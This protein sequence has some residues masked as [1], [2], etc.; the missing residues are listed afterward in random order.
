MRRIKSGVA[1][2]GP[3]LRVVLPDPG[4]GTGTHTSATPAQYMIR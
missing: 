4:P 1:V 3:G 2:R